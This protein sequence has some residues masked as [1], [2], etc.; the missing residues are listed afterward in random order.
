MIN[1]HLRHKLCFQSRC[2][3]Y[4]CMLNSWGHGKA[5]TFSKRVIICVLAFKAA[6]LLPLINHHDRSVPWEA[7]AVPL[8]VWTCFWEIKCTWGGGRGLRR[9]LY[10]QLLEDGVLVGGRGGWGA[11][12]GS[13]H[14]GNTAGTQWLQSKIGRRE[15]QKAESNPFK[16]PE[17]IERFPPARKVG[18]ATKGLLKSFTLVITTGLRLLQAEG[19]IINS[20]ALKTPTVKE[21]NATVSKRA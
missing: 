17:L 15:V 12:D 4:Y 18:T 6:S 9:L 20:Y 14:G 2:W 11:G 7:E 21:T 8:Y 13:Q 10:R 19:A 16:P 1:F 5:V 3:G